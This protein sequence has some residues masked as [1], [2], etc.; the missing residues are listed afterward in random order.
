MAR[1]GTKGHARGRH[2]LVDDV[3]GGRTKGH[4]RGRHSLVDDVAGGRTKGHARGRHS[5]H[6]SWLH[7]QQF[8][9]YSE[10]LKHIEA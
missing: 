1:G 10:Q 9:N 5:L 7:L 6:T 3:A 8:G 4:A 2:S